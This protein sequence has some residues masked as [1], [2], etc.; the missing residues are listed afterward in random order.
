M[1]GYAPLL[2]DYDWVSQVWDELASSGRTAVCGPASTVVCEPQSATI[3]DGSIV[4]KYASILTRTE[5]GFDDHLISQFV[6]GVGNI[7][8]CRKKPTQ[9]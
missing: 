7:G 3:A 6:R 4:L 2:R 1:A 9:H 5:H 8:V